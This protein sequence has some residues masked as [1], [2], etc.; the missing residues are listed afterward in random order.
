MAFFGDDKKI[1]LAGD[2]CVFLETENGTVFR[3]M[4]AHN[5]G[6]KVMLDRMAAVL[7]VVPRSSNIVDIYAHDPSR[8]KKDQSD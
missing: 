6:F 1:K 3:I 8:K 7:S 5:G 2:T 4:A